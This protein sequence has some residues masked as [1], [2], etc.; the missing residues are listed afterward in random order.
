MDSLT[1]RFVGPPRLLV[2]ALMSGTSGA[3]RAFGVFEKQQRCNKLS[4]HGF[5]DALC[6]KDVSLEASADPVTP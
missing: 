6:Q 5:L 2:L 3:L 1:A 4:L